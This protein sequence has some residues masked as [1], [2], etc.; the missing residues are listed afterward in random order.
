MLRARISS[1][2]LRSRLL[3]DVFF[4]SLRTSYVPAK[5]PRSRFFYIARIPPFRQF[6]LNYNA[7]S[8]HPVDLRLT[9][10]F[11]IIVCLLKT[12]IERMKNGCKG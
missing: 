5:L 1:L 6:Y 12:V 2:I 11:E 8:L 4:P 10:P 3:T 7:F 9:I